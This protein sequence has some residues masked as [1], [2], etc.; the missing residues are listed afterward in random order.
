[1][2]R[3]LAAIVR[4]PNHR[5]RVSFDNP[6]T[7]VRPLP[8]LPR[9]YLNRRDLLEVSSQP[10]LS[11]HLLEVVL[12]KARMD[13]RPSRLAFCDDDGGGGGDDGGDGGGGDGDDLSDDDDRGHRCSSC[14]IPR[15]Y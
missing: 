12:A 6:L 2:A 7:I 15:S 1:M 5:S 9:N 4:P 3:T 8:P 10:L 13:R 11:D 14:R